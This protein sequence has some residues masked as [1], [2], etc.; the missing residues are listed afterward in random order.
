M[1]ERIILQLINEFMSCNSR[2]FP[3]EHLDV[4]DKFMLAY[5][6]RRKVED[7]EKAGKSDNLR[8]TNF[9]KEVLFRMRDLGYKPSSEVLDT[10]NNYIL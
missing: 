4:A 8:S 9:V 7:W 2:D 10:D 3:H 5:C 1:D 6:V